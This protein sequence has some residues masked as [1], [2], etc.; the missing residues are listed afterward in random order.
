MGYLALDCTGET[1]SCGLLTENGRFNEIRG[2]NPRRALLEMPAHIAHLMNL[3][4]LDYRDL[5]GVGVP[6]GPGSFTG[7]RLGLTLAKTIAFSS[8]CGLCAPDTLECLADGYRERFSGRAG[9]LAVALDARRGELYCGIFSTRRGEVV[10][11]TGVRNP[12]QFLQSLGQ[13]EDV[14]A[15]IGAGFAAYPELVPADF[16]GPVARGRAETALC[17]FALA[18]RT[19]EAAEAGTLQAPDSVTPAYHRQ[20]DIQVSG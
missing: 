15:L 19:R 6:L 11:P 4:D 7:V 3:A 9:L 1:Y 2:L 5:K 18:S 17:M 8:G 20:A 12:E 16:T 14:L 13:R 10:L